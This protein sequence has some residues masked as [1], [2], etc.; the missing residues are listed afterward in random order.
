M[1]QV[2]LIS[3]DIIFLIYFMFMYDDFRCLYIYIQIYIH[4]CISCAYHIYI[5]YIYTY[6]MYI[7]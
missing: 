2:I 1:V 3:Y 6:I 7:F 5:T 4:R